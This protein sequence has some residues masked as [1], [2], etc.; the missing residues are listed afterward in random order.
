MW[1][2][3]LQ[4]LPRGWGGGWNEMQMEFPNVHLYITS[5]VLQVTYTNCEILA[6]QKC[7]GMAY[8]TT[9]QHTCFYTSYTEGALCNVCCSVSILYR[10]FINSLEN[11]NMFSFHSSDFGRLW[12]CMN[13]LI[14]VLILICHK[15]K[16]KQKKQKKSM[17]TKRSPCT[18]KAPNF[19]PHQTGV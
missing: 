3:F 6:L 12:L 5:Q 15:K 14:W 10:L 4:N 1:G 16:Q 17:N 9:R 8:D 2:Y 18:L 7:I 19:F 11:I 13:I